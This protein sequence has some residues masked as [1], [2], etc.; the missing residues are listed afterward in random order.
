MQLNRKDYKKLRPN[1]RLRNRSV[2]I[3]KGRGLKP[4]D[5]PNATL[6]TNVKLLRRR[7][8]KRKESANSVSLKKNLGSSLRGNVKLRRRSDVQLR[9][10]DCKKLRRRERPNNITHKWAVTLSLLRTCP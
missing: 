1:V 9:R 7:D 8:K 2:K 3:R 4:K 6:K 5:K 10:K